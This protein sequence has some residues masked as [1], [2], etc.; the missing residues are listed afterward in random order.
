MGE[1]PKHPYMSHQAALPCEVIS[2]LAFSQE[3][4]I[5]LM[6]WP[7]ALRSLL[8]RF[9]SQDQALLAWLHS[10]QTSSAQKLVLLQETL[11]HVGQGP[12]FSGAVEKTRR[13]PCVLESHLRVPHTMTSLLQA[14]LPG[15]PLPSPKDLTSRKFS[16]VSSNLPMAPLSSLLLHTVIL[17]L[18][19][20][21][22]VYSTHAPSEMVPRPSV[23]H[24]ED[25]SQQSS[26]ADSLS[27]VDPYPPQLGNPSWGV[28]GVS[29]EPSHTLPHSNHGNPSSLCRIY[30]GFI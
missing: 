22:P 30:H 24:W 26:A 20:R 15:H 23:K 8:L 2:C 14:C 21:A 3:A 28:N 12:S 19:S 27:P 1:S 6:L 16:S 29:G 10:K 18:P 7:Q 11:A 9:L 25:P 13:Q 17:A 5:V 4:G